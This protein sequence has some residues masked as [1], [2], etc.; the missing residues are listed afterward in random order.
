M[1]IIPIFDKFSYLHGVN[2]GVVGVIRV[3]PG[4]AGDPPCGLL[5]AEER[6]V[7]V[8]EAGWWGGQGRCSPSH[9]FRYQVI[10]LPLLQHSATHYAGDTV[11]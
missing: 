4:A 9:V 2:N 11:S 7:V 8:V 10:H 6:V 1:Y 3:I 5:E